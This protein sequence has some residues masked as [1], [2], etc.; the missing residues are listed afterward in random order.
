MYF[1]NKGIPVIELGFAIQGAGI[2]Y[3]GYRN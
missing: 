3:Y 1:L 2:K